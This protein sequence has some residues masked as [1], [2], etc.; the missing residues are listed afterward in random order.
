VQLE[1]VRLVLP[2]G[3]ALREHRVTGEITVLCV[4]GLIEFTAHGRSQRMSPGQL[5]HLAAGE[6][7]AVLALDDAT[8]LLT[9]CLAPA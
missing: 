9:I 6:P 8:A 2:R 5:V 3:K 7:H 4:E 1:L